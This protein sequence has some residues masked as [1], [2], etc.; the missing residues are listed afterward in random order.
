MSKKSIIR[1]NFI[2]SFIFGLIMGLIFPIFASFFVTFNSQTDMIIFSVLCVLAGVVVGLTA[3]NITKF[4]IIKIIKEIDNQM[5]KLVTGAGDPAKGIDLESDDSLGSLVCSF[6]GFLNSA[7]NMSQI[8]GRIVKRDDEISKNLIEQYNKNLKSQD[9]FEETVKEI[10]DSFESQDKKLSRS[11]SSLLS[12][13]DNSSQLVK[14]LENQK[15]NISN[16]GK[17]MDR[18][19]ESIKVTESVMSDQSEKGNML[20]V[21]IKNSEDKSSATDKT[22]H[23]I[24]KQASKVLQIINQINDI[25]ERTNLLAMNA[26]IEAAHAGEKGRGFA[27]V[28]GEIRILAENTGKYSSEITANLMEINEMV[29]SATLHSRES[30]A[31]VDALKEIVGDFISYQNKARENMTELIDIGNDLNREISQLSHSEQELLSFSG[32]IDEEIDSI[33]L[34]MAETVE[35]MKNSELGMMKIHDEMNRL[36]TGSRQIYELLEENRN[37]ISQSENELKFFRKGI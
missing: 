20:L 15:N 17:A 3:F 36:G 18:A 21:N 8:L 25:S 33:R 29:E 16:S 1:K 28:A 12:I 19:V 35:T 5:E 37:E 10:N 22:I 30:R 14:V 24:A 4:T 32:K 6:N 27:V 34:I 7:G 9:G 13:E 2:L 31:A 26:S 11:V 23:N